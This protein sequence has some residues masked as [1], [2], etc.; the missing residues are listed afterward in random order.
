MLTHLYS[1][2]SLPSRV[3]ILGG[4]GFIG[5]ELSM[6]LKN[7]GIETLILSSSSINLIKKKSGDDLVD[8]LREDDVLV[9]AA[10]IAPVKNIDSFQRNISILENIRYAIDIKNIAQ[11]VNISSDA[12]YADGPLPLKECSSRAPE[13]LHGLMHLTREV[14]F[15]ELSFP[16]A[17]IRPTLVFGKDDPHNGYGPNSFARLAIGEQD[18]KLFGKGE[19]KRDHIFVRDVAE[20]ISLMILF[21]STGELNAT[22]GLVTS[23]RD[24]ASLLIKLSNS[25]SKIIN[26]KRFGPMPHGGLR[27]F[28]NSEI[29][30]AFPS[31]KFTPI[32]DSFLEYFD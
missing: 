7:K 24:I 30:K 28:D 2:A 14:V 3:V 25:S 26:T 32:K 19:E 17:T 27:T 8:I 5:N 9:I 15:S 4:T 18:I 23:F 29:S 20:L 1:T 12:I 22:T 31:F 11:L 16:Y 21:K 13:S 6:N 10:A